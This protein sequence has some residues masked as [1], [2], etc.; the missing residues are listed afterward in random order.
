MRVVQLQ[1]FG[2]PEVLTVVEAPDPVPGPGQIVMTV[3]GAGVNS[4]DV[5]TRSGSYHKAFQPPL[6]LGSEAAGTITA[7]GPDVEELHVGQRV[8]ALGRPNLPGFYAEQ[9]AVFAPFVV[10]V[11]DE[12]ALI[13]AA[14]LPIAWGTAWY[15][16]NRLGGLHAGQTVLVHAAAS[17]VGSA[18]VQLAAAAGAHVIAAAGGEVKTAWVAELG[19]EHV[20]NSQALTGDRLPARVV[21]LTDGRGADLVLDTVGG[22]VFAQ[23]LKAVAYGGTVVALA[24]VGLAPSVIDT[25]DFYPKNATI[26]GFQITNLLEHGYDPRPDLKELLA[27]LAS[28]AVRVPVTA[29]YGLADAAEAHRRLQDRGNYGKVMLAPAGESSR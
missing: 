1:E 22:E 18:A 14:A 4:V 5:L 8:L 28:K 20:L 9:A 3:E 19:A 15:C 25:R 12:V 27:T 7:V 16:L 24:N 29:V 23:S 21:E 6:I 26:R 13:D 11:P 2:G 10:P 17:G